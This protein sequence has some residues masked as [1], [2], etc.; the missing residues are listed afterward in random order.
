M[1]RLSTSARRGVEASRLAQVDEDEIPA[2]LQWLVAWRQQQQ[3]IAIQEALERLGQRQGWAEAQLQLIQADKDRVRSMATGSGRPWQVGLSYY[4]ATAAA[5]LSLVTDSQSARY[6]YTLL[7]VIVHNVYQQCLQ[8]ATPETWVPVSAEAHQF[9][10]DLASLDGE[11]R[12]KAAEQARQGARVSAAPD[13]PEPLKA[14]RR[15]GKRPNPQRRDAIRNAISKH[16]KPWRDHLNEIFTDLD[17]SQEVALGN[18]QGMKIDVGE[19]VDRPVLTWADLDLAA[20][21]QRRKILD[22]LRKYMID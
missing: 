3:D 8:G 11:F 21:K 2:P 13:Y 4:T 10:A 22:V 14:A 20:G 7:P 9:Q 16:G 17:S 15:R 5:W 18:F 12:K 19:G 6:F 1:N